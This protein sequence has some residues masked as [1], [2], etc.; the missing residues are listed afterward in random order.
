MVRFTT[1]K[2]AALLPHVQVF[3]GVRRYLELGNDFMRRGHPFT[4]FHPGG[5][6]PEWLPFHG[7]TRP[8]SAVSEGTFDV[9]LCSEYSILD[10]FSDLRARGKFFYFVLEG[11][12][13]EKE[14][15][16]SGL[17]L[18]ANSEG[19]ARRIER[20]YGVSC[21]RAP[22]GV[23]PDLFHPLPL[24]DRPRRDTFNILCYGRIY[25][26][27]KG[28]RYVLRAVDGL[29]R[30]YPNLRLIFFDTLVGDD[31]R[32]PRPL[33]RT[34]VP[35]DFHL[36][37]PQDRMA[38]L[39]GQ[40]DLFVSAERRAGWSNTTAEA[41]ACRLPVV[42]TPSGT[43]DFAFD[44][45]TALVAPIP[46]PILLRRRIRRLIEDPSLRERLAEAGYR[47][48]GEF[49][50]PALADRLLAVFASQTGQTGQN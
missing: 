43:R 50:W 47:M 18:L 44:G 8:F 21:L 17:S 14:V 7:E 26:R 13:R 39:F 35:F 37:L 20:K 46:A 22:G 4:L 2:I 30:R 42:C 25:K 33:V 34:R 9:G 3:G 45:R 31:R 49:T 36:G 23:N 19:L 10:R 6:A 1:M 48:I 24:P 38:W 29:A 27:R 40:A 41:M 32:D 11:H 28:V 16:R 15:A 5:E 12:N